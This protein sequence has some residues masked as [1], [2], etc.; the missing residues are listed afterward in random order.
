S[1]RKHKCHDK[2]SVTPNISPASR[3]C[4]SP[5]CTPSARHPF[6]FRASCRQVW[7]FRSVYI[8]SVDRCVFTLVPLLAIFAA[9]L[10]IIGSAIS[11]YDSL[12]R[13]GGR[14]L[15]PAPPNITFARIEALT[16]YRL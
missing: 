13:F 4:L 12:Q 3:Y 15:A 14:A 11:R 10:S 2:E 5:L 8:C 9:F 1:R 7:L 16:L 6:P